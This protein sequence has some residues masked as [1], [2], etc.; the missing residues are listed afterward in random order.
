MLDVKQV[1]KQLS[2]LCFLRPCGQEC[3]ILRFPAAASIHVLPAG[4]RTVF[5]TLSV[6]WQ[7]VAW[8]F[9][10]QDLEC[11]LIYISGCSEEGGKKT[12]NITNFLPYIRNVSENSAS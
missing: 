8:L 3:D 6:P 9:L 7:M 4:C 2:F 10:P 12:V 1:R 5:V 11:V